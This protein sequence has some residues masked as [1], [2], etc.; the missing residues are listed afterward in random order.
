[1]LRFR[2][3]ELIAEKD[4]RIAQLTTEVETIRMEDS[5]EVNPEAEEITP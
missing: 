4:N 1:M 3:K 5:L 2:I